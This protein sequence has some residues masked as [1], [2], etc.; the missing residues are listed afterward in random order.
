MNE[1]GIPI[2]HIIG[3]V[4]AG[5][6]RFINQ[7][8]PNRTAFDIQN[9]YRD[10]QFTP[11]DLQNPGKYTQFAEALKTA[12]ENYLFHLNE[13]EQPWSII[14]SSGINLALNKI[15]QSKN[16]LTIWIHPDFRLITGEVFLKAHPYARDLNDLILKKKSTNQ[17]TFDLEYYYE[18]DG[19]SQPI[20]D[21]FKI[22]FTDPKA[23]SKKSAEEVEQ[24]KW[25]K[26]YRYPKY[27]CPTCQAEFSKS[28][29]LAAHFK[30]YPSC[31]DQ[32]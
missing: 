25:K 2:I 21:E 5:K 10:D 6:T 20:P 18:R 27:V 31:Y 14:E 22:A 32:W 1:E 17:M 3:C 29:F 15:L 24:E 23:V 12:F 26:Y 9:V 11:A 7:Y 30:R 8:W 28:A 13:I 4:W 16:V 19:F